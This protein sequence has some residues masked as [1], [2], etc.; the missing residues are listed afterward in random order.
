MGQVTIYLDAELEA[1]MR[2]ITKSMHM[3]QSKWIANLIKEK[4]ADEWPES[5]KKLAGSWGDFPSAEEIRGNSRE[6][7]I[8]E[9]L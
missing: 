1:K 2:E 8:R 4:I 9:D 5:V 7:S 6:D 3:S